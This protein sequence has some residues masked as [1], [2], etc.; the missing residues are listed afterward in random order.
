MLK[1]QQKFQGHNILSFSFRTKKTII[2]FCLYLLNT[3]IYKKSNF[4]ICN[5]NYRSLIYT[6]YY[7]IKRIFLIF[8]CFIFINIMSW[9]HDLDT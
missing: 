2:F 4:I 8:Y 1:K 6:F 7:T 9:S 5:Y 3:I